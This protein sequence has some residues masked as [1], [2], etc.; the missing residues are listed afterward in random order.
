[1]R[2]KLFKLI[3]IAIL[4]VISLL[5]YKRQQQSN[6]QTPRFVLNFG[7]S[8]TI[9]S[10][11]QPFF[12]SQI[13]PQPKY[14]PAAHSS[15]FTKLANGDLLAFWFA[16]TR[17][18]NPDVKIWSSRYHNGR[19]QMA[20]ALLDPQ[21]IAK[22]NHRYVI[23]V[24]N[25][26]IYRAKNG[27]L[28]LFVVSVSIGGWSGSTLNHLTSIDNGYTWSKP[29]RI[30]ISPFLNIS[31]L[32]RTSAVSLDDGGFYL[33]VY[34]ELI[35]KYPELLRFDANGNFIQQIR[36]TN[37]NKMLQPSVVPLSATDAWAYFRNSSNQTESRIMYASFTQDGGSHW[38]EPQMTNLTNPD[39]SLEAA[40]LGNGLLLMAYNDQD[41]SH[42]LLGISK[43]GLTWKPI[44]VLENHSGDEFS[45]PALQINGD[46]IDI[47]Y[48]NNRQNIKHI[49]FNRAWLNR[50]IN[51]A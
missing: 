8:E 32:V 10:S 49:R 6:L 34:Q 27:T 31:T 44:Y 15:S 13:I 36:I 30:V 20:A 9:S 24:G 39:S 35:R 48:T 1:M 26:V 19:W 45:Y 50:V 22:A 43:D 37:K 5:I 41:R 23:K 33:P 4:I 29:I 17:E 51:H 46:I 3:A 28:H 7:E 38:S 11:D 14:L 40:N 18:G 16:G 25:P 12:E 2:F 42:L 21:M 47:L